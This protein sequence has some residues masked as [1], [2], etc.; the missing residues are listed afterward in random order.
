MPRWIQHHKYMASSHANIQFS[1]LKIEGKIVHAKS[2]LL[3]MLE[4]SSRILH[5]LSLSHY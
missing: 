5:G 2:S 3:Y 4:S 1:I